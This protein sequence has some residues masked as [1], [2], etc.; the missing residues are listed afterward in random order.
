AQPYPNRPIRIVVPFAPGGGTDILIRALAPEVSRTLGQQLVID[1]KPGGAS[2]IGTQAVIDSAPDGYTVLAV[3]TALLTNPGL[4]GSKLP[5]DAIKQLT[6]ITMLASGPVPLLLHPSVPATD[7]KSLVALAKAKPGTLNFGSG[8]NG[9][10]PHLAGALF[11]LV[12]GID[13]VHVPYK[14]TAPA[15]SDLVAGQLQMMFGGISSSRPFVEAGKLR[16]VAMSAPKRNAAMPDVPTFEEAGLKG[17]DVESYWGLYAP[18][19]TPAE[20]IKIL[21]EHF[22][23]ALSQP[24]IVEQLK[25]LGFEVIANSPQEHTAQY[26]RLTGQWSET[27]KKADIKME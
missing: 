18:A 19:G 26:A 9:S 8:G 12:A 23:R 20:A 13:I 17:I 3:D 24:K 14:G 25:E 5:Y 16:A 27:I 11:K 2:V 1:N 10:G 6:G 15:L 7:L 22:V 21:N 4:F